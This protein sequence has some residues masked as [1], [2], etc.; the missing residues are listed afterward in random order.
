MCHTE[1]VYTP[2]TGTGTGCISAQRQSETHVK[3]V[4]CAVSLHPQTMVEQRHDK[5]PSGQFL[6]G[7]VARRPETVALG[8]IIIIANV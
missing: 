3:G 2:S 6:Y 7:P 4:G 5:F 8:D 1:Y